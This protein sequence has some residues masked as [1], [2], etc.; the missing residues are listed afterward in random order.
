MYEEIPKMHYEQ[1][2]GSVS[3]YTDYLVDLQRVA[4][5]RKIPFNVFGFADRI[6]FL[7]RRKNGSYANL[8]LDYWENMQERYDCCIEDTNIELERII[9]NGNKNIRD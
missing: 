5:Y 8:E 7:H 2:D 9:Q 6:Y 4:N 3:R 1:R